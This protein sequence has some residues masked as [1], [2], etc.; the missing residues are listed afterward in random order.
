MTEAAC[1]FGSYD[2]RVL[3]FLRGHGY[4]RAYHERSRHGPA[5]DW[6]QAAQ[7][8]PPRRRGCGLIDR[9]LADGATRNGLRRR[10]KLAAKRWR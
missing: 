6:I 5:D 7:H 9:V 10:A 3:R 8:R 4:R 2:R 1:P